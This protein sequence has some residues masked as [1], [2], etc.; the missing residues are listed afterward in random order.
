MA[1]V[2]GSKDFRESV[3]TL[4]NYRSSNGE[5][6]QCRAAHPD[7]HVSACVGPLSGRARV[8]VT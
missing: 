5:G 4:D 6:A 1:S 3:F 2:A 7:H 8:Q